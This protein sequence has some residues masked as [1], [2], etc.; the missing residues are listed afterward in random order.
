MRVSSVV[1]E[2]QLTLLA[3]FASCLLQ[4]FLQTSVLPTQYTT[5]C[6]LCVLRLIT[7][8]WLKWLLI[9]NNITVSFAHTVSQLAQQQGQIISLLTA[10]VQ[11]Q[12]TQPSVPVPSQQSPVASRPLPAIYW[13][14]PTAGCLT[15]II[16]P[17]PAI[18]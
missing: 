18:Y 17:L 1:L 4:A 11:Q 6:Q 14:T 8:Q 3:K 15:V 9:I 13:H 2:H 7:L 5:V 12:I 16:H 10:L